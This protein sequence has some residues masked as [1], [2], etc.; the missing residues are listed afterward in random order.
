MSQERALA[1]WLARELPSAVNG[2]MSLASAIE[3]FVIE[4]KDNDVTFDMRAM[5]RVLASDVA[6]MQNAMVVLLHRLPWDR[7]RDIVS[8]PER[9]RWQSEDVVAALVASMKLEESLL[10]Q[11][12]CSKL[13]QDMFQLK[14]ALQ[15]YKVDAVDGPFWYSARRQWNM[16]FKQ[17]V[18]RKQS[19]VHIRVSKLSDLTRAIDQTSG[20]VQIANTRH[21]D[22]Q[23]DLAPL[24]DSTASR[25]RPTDQLVSAGRRRSNSIG[26]STK[27][28]TYP[29][30]NTETIIGL[31]FNLQI[32]RDKGRLPYVY[33]DVL[34]A[35]DKCL[36]TQQRALLD[37][38]NTDSAISER[39][40]SK[41]D[42]NYHDVKIHTTVSTMSQVDIPVKYRVALKLEWENMRGAPELRWFYVIFMPLFQDLVLSND[43]KLDHPDIERNVQHEIS[44]GSQMNLTFFRR[45]SR[46]Q[47][48]AADD[49]WEE[50]AAKN[51]KKTATDKDARAKKLAEIF[52]NV[53]I[54]TQC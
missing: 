9:S 18:L 52:K 50:Q 36:V 47:Q 1:E 8:Y 21:L 37:S 15:D 27:V 33:I 53:V 42:L 22:K 28:C 20:I 29:S 14:A 3:V 17:D 2:L 32:V 49:I 41:L 44:Q 19:Q 39:L 12:R 35:K 26:P 34:S 4:N 13:F 10:L 24:P 31:M 5:H 51:R 43:F 11:L 6:T 30:C 45:M 16:T 40:A 48:Q 23:Q 25:R 46:T 54:G 38:G 7:I